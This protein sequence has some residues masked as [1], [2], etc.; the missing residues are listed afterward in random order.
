MSLRPVAFP[1]TIFYDASCPLC[2]TEMHALKDRDRHGRLVLVDCSD[3]GFSDGGAASCGV[4]R[5]DMMAA[6]HARDAHGRWLRGV[7]VFEQAY[8][9][10]GLSAI[11]RLWGHRRL[12]PVRERAYPWVA[13]HR[14]Q[15]SRFGLPRV[16]RWVLAA[17]SRGRDPSPRLRSGQASLR[18]S[19]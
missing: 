16:L 1:L 15:L 8:A 13:R 5:S 2:A 7:E 18:S 6:I 11:A 3:A 9:A 12:R 19:G 14:Q 4:T 10:V 17:A